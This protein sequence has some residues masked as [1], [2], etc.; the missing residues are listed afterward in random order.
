MEKKNQKD[1]KQKQI[2][3]ILA[4]KSVVIQ[5]RTGTRYEGQ[6]AGY[7]N[8]FFALKNATVYGTRHV[9]KTS[10]LLVDRSIICHMHLK[11]SEVRKI[12]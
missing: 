12:E 7:R 4:G 5:S 2:A 9:A 1:Q 3:E 11:P 10:F 8:G 6:I